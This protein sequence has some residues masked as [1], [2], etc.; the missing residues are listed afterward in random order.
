MTQVHRTERRSAAR[1]DAARRRAEGRASRPR[2]SWT[3]RAK[4]R[5]PGALVVDVRGQH[6]LPAGLAAFRKQ[7]PGTRRRA[8]RVDARS[9]PDARGDARRRDRVR[10]GAVTPRRSIDAVRRVLV[11]APPDQRASV[12]VRRRQGRRRHH[13]ARGEHRRRARAVAGRRRAADRSAHR[14]WR[15]RAVRS[16]SSR[17]SRCST[18]SR[19]SIASTSRSSAAWSRKPRSGVD[20]LGSSDRDR[21]TAPI[22]PQ[23]IRALLD[24]ATRKYR[25]TVLDVPRSDVAMLDVARDRHDDRRRHQPG[26]PSLRSAGRLGADAAH[27]LRRGAREGGRQPVR[28]QAPRSRRPTSSGSIGD[29]VKH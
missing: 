12:G 22:D 27:A 2:R 7:H 19:T 20:L 16:A 14:P 9:A 23:R 28:S 10:P 18:R 17:A 15:R 29:T 6:Q 1:R 24:F 21:C 25:Y 4:D 3:R 13:H 5:S 8:R 11:D 26:V